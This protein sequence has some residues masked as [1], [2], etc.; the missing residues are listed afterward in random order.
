MVPSRTASTRHR[1]AVDRR[2]KE[3]PRKTGETLRDRAAE[4]E[5]VR[6]F[7]RLCGEGQDNC[8]ELSFHIPSGLSQ[9]E[10]LDAGFAIDGHSATKS[11]VWGEY[12]EHLSMSDALLEAQRDLVAWL[13]E[14]GYDVEFK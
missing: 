10:L 6:V 5:R 11:A 13:A 12:S 2:R 7:V 3:M 1:P 9:M 4:R 8:R 14:R